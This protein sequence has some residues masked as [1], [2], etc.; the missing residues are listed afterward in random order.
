MELRGKNFNIC[1]WIKKL[2]SL[3]CDRKELNKVLYLHHPGFCS[4][5]INSLH[6]GLQMSMKFSFYNFFADLDPRSRYNFNVF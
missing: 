2:K 4:A 5:I 6:G 3:C 1:E